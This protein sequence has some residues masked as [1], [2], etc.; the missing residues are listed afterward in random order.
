MPPENSQKARIWN[1]IPQWVTL[2]LVIGGIIG[3]SMLTAFKLLDDVGDNSVK[4]T[5]VEREHSVRIEAVKLAMD[6]T[7]RDAQLEFNKL[8]SRLG[9]LDTQQ[10]LMIQRQENEAKT[11]KDYRERA[12][13]S[14]S[15]QWQVLRE[16]LRR[17]NDNTVRPR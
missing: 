15:R 5:R 4:I 8:N 11:Q 2:T 7:K 10:Q 13:K 3:G 1:L 16:L 12:E 14:S 17:Q 9:S 6:Q